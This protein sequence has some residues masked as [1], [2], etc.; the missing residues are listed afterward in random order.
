VSGASAGG[1]APGAASG[2]PAASSASSPS[3][4]AAPAGAANGA[5]AGSAPAPASQGVFGIAVGTYL[6]E[7]R[8]EEERVKLS[9]STSLPARVIT[10]TETD[11]TVYRLVLGSFD[12]R[13]SAERTA[14][15]LIERGLV[16]EA[17]VVPLSSTTA[18][19]Q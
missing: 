19:K 3:T 2:A 9:A 7:D 6:F 5:S 4:S 8:A 17:R 1:A 18:S 14:S 13:K 12:S 10:V 15:S 16:D 11:E